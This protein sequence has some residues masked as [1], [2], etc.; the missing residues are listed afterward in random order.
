MD[1]DEQVGTQDRILF[2]LKPRATKKEREKEPQPTAGNSKR[3]KL[4]EKKKNRHLSVSLSFFPRLCFL[5][6]FLRI[7]LL[8][9]VSSVCLQ[10]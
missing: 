10:K 9:C 1:G 4:A 5:V 3:L 6:S 2:I 8:V 7:R